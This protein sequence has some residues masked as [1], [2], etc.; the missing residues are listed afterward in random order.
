MKRSLEKIAVFFRGSIV[1]SVIG[2]RNR[3][4]RRALHYILYSGLSMLKVVQMRFHN[5]NEPET[6]TPD[7]WVSCWPA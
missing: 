4:Q 2:I 1:E 6:L 5:M 7:S 3:A